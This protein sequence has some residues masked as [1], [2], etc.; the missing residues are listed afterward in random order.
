[1]CYLETPDIFT[2]RTQPKLVPRH[3]SACSTNFGCVS[4]YVIY[5]IY[6]NC[7]QLQCIEVAE[8]GQLSTQR[9]YNNR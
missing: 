1:L 7:S 2:R 3:F 5:F 8:Y 6:L 4:L 9:W